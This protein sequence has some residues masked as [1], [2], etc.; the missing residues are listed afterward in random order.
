MYNFFSGAGLEEAPDAPGF[1]P[2]LNPSVGVVMEVGHTRQGS[3]LQWEP[4]ELNTEYH[5]WATDTRKNR[6]K[7]LG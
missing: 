1:A 5:G 2:S 4:L 6:I 3:L 7:D